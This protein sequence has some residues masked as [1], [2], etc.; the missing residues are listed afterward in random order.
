MVRLTGYQDVKQQT[1][2]L[3]LFTFFNKHEVWNKL[4]F[5]D[6]NHVKCTAKIPKITNSYS[7]LPNLKLFVKQQKVYLHLD[8][9]RRNDVP[10]HNKQ[11]K[12]NR[13]ILGRFI[14]A[15]K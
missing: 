15:K 5:L 7:L 8:T 2:M 1:L 9:Q 14:V 3:A 13:I 11:V 6:F 4:G 12:K 10:K